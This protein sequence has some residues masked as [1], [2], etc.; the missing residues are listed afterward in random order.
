MINRHR[1]KKIM[2]SVIILTILLWI[3]A[4]AIIN[5]SL[6]GGWILLIFAIVASILSICMVCVWLIGKIK[7]GIS[8]YKLFGIA[9]MI[10]EVI[11]VS[12]AIYDMLTD[13]GIMAG[14]AG[15]LL[16]CF[17]APIPLVL[18]VIDIIL[19]IKSK[20]KKDIKSNE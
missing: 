4:A 18:L 13:T 12:Y 14:I 15:F 6:S 1:V 11:I 20:K 19:Y 16:M 17:V 3:M 2:I 9:D 10:I 8:P 7:H 5:Y